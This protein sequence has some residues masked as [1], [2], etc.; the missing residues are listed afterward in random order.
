[1]QE[2]KLDKKHITTQ[3]IVFVGFLAFVAL[4]LTLP[5]FPPGENWHP[6][7]ARI[8]S[9]IFIVL[10][11]ACAFSSWRTLKKLPYMDV[12]ADDDGI[13]YA[14]IG[15]D[16]GL[17][18]WEKISGVKERPRMQCLDL[19]ASHGEKLLTVEYQ[20]RD[21]EG[22][23]DLLNERTSG[24]DPETGQTGQ[25]TFSKPSSYHLTNLLMVLG[26]PILGFFCAKVQGAAFW[27][28]AMCVTVI[29]IGYE[30]FVTPTGIH[31]DLRRFVVN[32]PFWETAID[33]SDVEEIKI[34]DKF[35]KGYRLP[36]VWIHSRNK[37]K[38]IKLKM[39]GVDSNVLYA[40]LQKA[41]D[42]Y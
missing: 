35:Y 23:R 24:A 25:S 13:W 34:T 7:G 4:G 2:F 18:A 1:M 22:L 42:R 21:F 16:K 27:G 15:K 39:L 41:V 30:Y 5:F 12:A 26:L 6:G 36:E 38:P 19:F 28:Y 31:V 32:Y 10:F 40:A 11:G 3:K 37:E 14:H 29:V 17:I 20:L 9:L 33:F 8:V